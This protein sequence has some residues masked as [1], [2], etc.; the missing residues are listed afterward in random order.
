MNINFVS[1]GIN[2]LHRLRR[3][4]SFSDVKYYDKKGVLDKKLGFSLSF[5]HEVKMNVK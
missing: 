2:V 4:A 1:S 3:T 5:F